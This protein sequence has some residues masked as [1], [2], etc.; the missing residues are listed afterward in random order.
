MERP[1]IILFNC[2]DLG[3]GD[4]GCYGSPVNRTPVLDKIA[5]EGIRFTDFYMA[6]PVCSPSR[7]ALMTG[8]YPPRIG[9]GEFDGQWVLFPGQP[10]GIHEE[11]KTLPQ[12]LRDQGYATKIIGKWHCGDQKEFLPT[13]R[14]FDEYYG[15]PYSNDM[16][17]QM[18]PNGLSP[19]PPLPL[20]RDD[21]V[22]QEQPEQASLTE[23]YTEE[24]VRFVRDKR[25]GPFFLYF[26]HM[27]VHVPL[28]VPPR[29]LKASQNGGYGGAVE[30]IDW[31]A[32]V[33]LDE[34]E[35]LGLTENTLV[36]FTSD[37][38]SRA[39]D[40]GGSNAPCRGT[41]GTTWEGGQRVPCL[42]KWPKGIPG[43]RVSSEIVSSMDFLPTL[44]SLAGGE[45]PKDRTIDG[46]DLSNLWTGKTEVSPRKTMAYYKR[47]DLQAVRRGDW[48]LH[49]HRTEDGQVK[50]LYHLTEDQGESRNLY[51]S[52]PDVAADLE[53]LAEEFRRELGDELT[54]T[55]G[56]GVRPKGR[57]ENPVPLTAYRED[58]PYMIAMY[59]L[60]D[61]HS[62]IMAG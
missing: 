39:R 54:G 36:I 50:E 53:A 8:C 33:I 34:L 14:G 20:I 5:R 27:Y 60:A 28:F 4:L 32:G 43:G 24:A 26:A 42:V 2:D 52:H 30:H 41:K 7:G 47:N 15:L 48:K 1:N 61:A 51:D 18:N 57:V 31:T 38:G 10:Y 21:E 11:E 59:D 23:R 58:H 25:E 62:K 29:F 3:Y 55:K 46:L 13:N 22:I 9:F 17:R 35:R 12:L 16:G 6:S 45:A 40:E 49:I 37:N 56:S 19:W 44:V